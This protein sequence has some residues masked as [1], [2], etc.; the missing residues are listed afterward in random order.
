MPRLAKPL[1]KYPI[2]KGYLLKRVHRHNAFCWFWCIQSSKLRSH[3]TTQIRGLRQLLKVS[4]LSKH[5]VPSKASLQLPHFQGIPVENIDTMFF[6]FWIWCI[7]SSKLR[8]HQTPHSRS[9]RKLLINLP[10]QPLDMSE[11]TLYLLRLGSYRLFI[12]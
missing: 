6:F 7:Q 9:L 11:Y 2:S 10:L 1:L 12:V 3:H 5:A 4:S 8:S